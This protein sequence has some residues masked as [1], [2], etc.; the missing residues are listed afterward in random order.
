MDLRNAIDTYYAAR[1]Q[2][3]ETPSGYVKEGQDYHGEATR[4]D[5]K[6]VYAT[7]TK[8]RLPLV[9]FPE[10]SYTDSNSG[11]LQALVPVE[12]LS[13]VFGA[14]W[15]DYK[16]VSFK[17]R[18]TES[19]GLPQADTHKAFLEE[20]KSH[21][22]AAIWNVW[23]SNGFTRL[24][25]EVYLTRDVEITATRKQSFSP[26]VGVKPGGGMAAG[27]SALDA[28][29]RVAEIKK[30]NDQLKSLKDPGGYFEVVS[31][32]DRSVTMKRI[33]YRP[34]V[35]GIKFMRYMRL[36]GR[37]EVVLLDSKEAETN[38]LIADILRKLK[39]G[40]LAPAMHNQSQ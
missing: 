7:D 21:K 36:P 27:W 13:V 31:V 8:K 28:A 22:G 29:G 12:A 17:M 11:N 23:P 25:N 1:F 10:F 5:G 19:Y 9:G 15:S 30:F 26:N 6:S 37:K 4:T 20:L 14:S 39:P 3:P 18:A 2:F 33:Y 24:I 35:V 34:I 38:P 32:S 40:D 16:S